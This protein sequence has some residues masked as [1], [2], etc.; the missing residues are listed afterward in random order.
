MNSNSNTVYIVNA[1]VCTAVIGA[2]LAAVLTGKADWTV[3]AGF[4][5]SVIAALLTPSAIH[6]ALSQKS[7]GGSQ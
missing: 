3:A 7:G 6:V 2:A 1:I 4:A 5:G